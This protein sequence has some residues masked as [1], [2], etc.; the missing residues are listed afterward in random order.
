MRFMKL[1]QV[2]DIPGCAGRH[3]VGAY[4]HCMLLL[5][6]ELFHFQL[7]H[8]WVVELDSSTPTKFSRHLIIRI[9][10]AAFANYTHVGA[11]VAKV[12]EKVQQRG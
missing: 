2:P 5:P 6:Q 3:Q 4:L 12:I 10:R 11:F 1:G 7:Q 8:D 9:K